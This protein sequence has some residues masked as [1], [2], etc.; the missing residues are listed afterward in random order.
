[1]HFTMSSAICF[2]LGQSKIFSSGNV[3]KTML[4]FKCFAPTDPIHSVY[5]CLSLYMDKGILGFKYSWETILHIFDIIYVCLC[6]FL[7]VC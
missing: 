1:M 7:K 3:L 5:A 6:L 2:N 4:T